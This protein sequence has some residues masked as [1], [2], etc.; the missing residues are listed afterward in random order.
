MK[1]FC[2]MLG[3][4]DFGQYLCTAKK[5]RDGL[6]HQRTK[7]QTG[8]RTQSEF[9][10]KVTLWIVPQQILAIQLDTVQLTYP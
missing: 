2:Q 9:A 6:C 1:S 5:G 10:K 7:T 3:N 4:L 8:V